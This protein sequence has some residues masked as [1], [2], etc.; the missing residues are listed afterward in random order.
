M[1]S[2]ALVTG[3]PG[4]LGSRLASVLAGGLAD[5]PALAVPEP[6]RVRCLVQPGT[7]TAALA[8]LPAGVEL[9]EGDVRD[10]RSLASFV[11]GA[12]GATV[13]HACGV[14]TPRRIRDFH[15]VDVD[16]TR[17]VLEAAVGANA[18][19]VIGIS[20]DT[21]AGWNRQPD[22]VFDE[23]SPPRPHL[24]Y[25]RS[26]RRMEDLLRNASAAGRLTTVILRPCRF[27]G[28]GQ[29]HARTRFYRLIRQGRLPREASQRARLGLRRSSSAGD[30]HLGLW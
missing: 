27:Y 19:R 21:V 7:P 10:P 8:E 22:E 28:P 13:F 24:H 29:P 25:G 20:S 2:P 6:R 3:A 26:K 11:R 1:N 16:G 23:R 9:V 14:V 12:E 4:W 15:D 30:A 5:T 18:A 17:H